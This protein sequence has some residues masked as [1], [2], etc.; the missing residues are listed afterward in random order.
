MNR[1]LT[2]QES[3]H[4]LA[5]DVCHGKRG[6]IHQVYRDGMEDQLGALGLVLNAI[7][8]W[9]TRYIDAAVAELKAEGHEIR[10]EDIVRLSPLK[11]RNLNVL[12][13]YSFTASTPAAGVLRS[14]RDPEA[15]GLDDDED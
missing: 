3:R 15:P 10:A 8:L 13:R 2:A 12:G 1:Q 7:A 5:R 11:H 14:P 6:T 9:T 4:K